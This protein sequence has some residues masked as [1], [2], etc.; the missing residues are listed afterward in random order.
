M[1]KERV[2][3]DKEGSGDGVIKGTILAF[4]WRD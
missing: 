4:A 2:E 1:N 3:K